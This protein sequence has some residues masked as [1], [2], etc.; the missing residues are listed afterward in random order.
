MTSF[1]P[2]EVRHTGGMPTEP[3][4]PRRRVVGA[5]LVDELTTPHMLLAARR[6]APSAHAGGWELPGGKVEPG[7]GE[8]EALHRELLEELG[9]EIR[10]GDQVP[11]PAGGAWPLGSA[12]VMT[13]W[14]CR[15][16]G[17]KRPEPLEDHDQVRWLAKGELFDVPWLPDD[18][19]VVEAVRR[20]MA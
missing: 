9:I 4:P 5:A 1:E 6:T 17:S 14:I 18:R 11:G 13:V 2:G 8:L 19:P 20:R 15:V 16:A 10:I 12:Y 3:D 7:E